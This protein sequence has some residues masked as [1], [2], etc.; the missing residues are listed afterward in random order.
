MVQRPVD[1]IGAD[2]VAPNARC[3]TESTSTNAGVSPSA[4]TSI[5]STER[6]GVRPRFGSSKAADAS[7][8]TRNE[9]TWRTP[10]S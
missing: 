9:R 1:E 10:C 3:R 5:P 7:A 6:P 2:L 4:G 8:A